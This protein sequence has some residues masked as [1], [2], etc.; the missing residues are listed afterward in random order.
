MIGLIRE[1]TCCFT[2]HRK[3]SGDT[4]W[5]RFQIQEEVLRLYQRGIST[6]LTGGALGFDTLAAKEILRLRDSYVPDL[7][8]AVVIPC[9]GQERGW[10][11]EDQAVY[12]S[13]LR[14]ADDRIMTGESYTRDCM[15]VRNRYMVDHSTHCIAW[16][17]PGRR[18]GT[19]YTVNYAKS[20]GLEVVNLFGRTSQ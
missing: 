15:F 11:T 14:K 9:W 18:G 16:L 4:L 7:L 10:R 1:R 6:F 3:L 19:S 12:Q 8:L 17:E 13:I 5:L 20:K 2:G